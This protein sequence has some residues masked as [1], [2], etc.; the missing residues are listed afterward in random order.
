M[1]RKVNVVE[2]LD[3]NRIVVIHDI[4]FKGK[5]SMEWTDEEEYLKR[6]ATF[7]S[8]KTLLSNKTHFLSLLYEIQNK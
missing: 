3:G 2:D 1:H 7:Y 8:T 4:I 6:R 5:L